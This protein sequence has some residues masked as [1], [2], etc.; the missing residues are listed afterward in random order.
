VKLLKISTVPQGGCRLVKAFNLA[1]HGLMFGHQQGIRIL[2]GQLFK[3]LCG[4]HARLYPAVNRP[5]LHIRVHV[6]QRAAPA[7]ARKSLGIRSPQKRTAVHSPGRQD[8]YPRGYRLAL[9]E[10]G[11][12]GFRRNI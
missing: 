11:F 1:L 4:H 3:Q 2:A 7:L 5:V 12:A 8:A 6:K 10:P 9:W